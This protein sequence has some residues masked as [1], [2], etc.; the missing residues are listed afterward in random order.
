MSTRSRDL[1]KLCCM[2]ALLALAA[3]FQPT[4]AQAQCTSSTGVAG[5]EGE[6][7]DPESASN[8]IGST[9]CIDEF[10]EERVFQ[11]ADLLS[12]MV[13][14]GIDDALDT[15]SARAL[16]HVQ[17]DGSVLATSGEF[18]HPIALYYNEGYFAGTGVLIGME[19]R[20]WFVDQWRSQGDAV[21]TEHDAFGPGFRVEWGDRL[22]DPVPGAEVVSRVDSTGVTW[23]HALVGEIPL[24]PGPGCT[25]FTYEGMAGSRLVYECHDIGGVPTGIWFRE[26]PDRRRVQYDA[27]PNSNDYRIV[28]EYR[29]DFQTPDWEVTY[30]Y[31][32][33]GTLELIT[34]ARGVEYHFAWTLIGGVPRVTSI[35]LTGPW[36]YG[37]TNLT[38]HFEYESVWP[39]RLERI[40]KPSRAF[41]EDWNRD[42]E[43]QTSEFLVGEIITRFT[44]VGNTYRISKIYDESSGSARLETEIAYE[45][46]NDGRVDWI[47]HGEPGSWPAGQGQ[48]VHDLSYAVDETHWT[49]PRGVE[50]RYYY[51]TSYGSSPLQWRIVRVEEIPGPNDAR[52]TTNPD[53]HG[54]LAWDFTWN[55][56]CG[57]LTSITTPSGLVY[58]FEYDAEG[59][60]LVTEFRIE[61][62]GGV[63][64]QHFRTWSY[65]SWDHP[66]YRIA[67][68]LLQFIDAEG[69][70]G[71]VDYTYQVATQEIRARLS[72][73]GEHLVDI[74]SDATDRP[75]RVE[76]AAFSIKGGGTSKNTLVYEHGTNPTDASYGL[77]VGIHQLDAGGN[78]AWSKTFDYDGLA[79]RTQMTDEKGR[80]TNYTVNYVGWIERIDLP[81]TPSGL[82][83]ATYGAYDEYERTR[84]GKVAVIRSSADRADGTPYPKGIVETERVFDYHGRLWKRYREN[85]MLDNATASSFV[86]EYEYDDSS[87]LRVVRGPGAFETTFVPDDHNA[88]YEYRQKIDGTT[89]SVRS[90]G[91]HEDGQPTRFVDAT[92]IESTVD[93]FDSFGR[94]EWLTLPAGQRVQFVFDKENR[95]LEE[96][97]YTGPNP[98]AL[99]RSM[100][101]DRDALGRVIAKSMESPSVTTSWTVTYTRNGPFRM[102]TLRDGNGRQLTF[103]YDQYG[104]LAS[105]SDNLTG[106]AANVLRYSRDALG[107]VHTLEQDLA[108]QTGSRSFATHTYMSTMQYDNWDRLVRIDRY[109]EGASILWTRELAYDSLDNLVRFEDATGAVTE[110]DFDVLGRERRERRF[111]KGGTNFIE[112]LTDYDDTPTDPGISSIM[113]RTDDRGNPSVYRFD[114]AG[115]LIE[116]RLPGY[117]AGT[118]THRQLLDYDLE[119]R[120]VGWTD[121]NGTQVALHYDA[122]GRR[123][124]REVLG[125]PSNAVELSRMATE[126]TWS[127][128]N[129][130]RTT[131]KMTWRGN[132]ATLEGSAAFGLVDSGASFDDI[133][134]MLTTSF[135]FGDDAAAG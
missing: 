87:R 106:G 77:L 109:G 108:R 14:V 26:Y 44:Y 1:F 71:T 104:R 83:S 101:W 128:D 93:S 43:Y 99:A 52:P 85:G 20:S 115:R 121:G 133:D 36:T 111:E 69:N 40:R 88:L 132:Y 86:V 105:R 122:A 25:P 9:T 35:S 11:T 31:A 80:T 51:D 27:N 41:V 13:P 24:N 98:Q 59:R 62:V 39:H 65:H 116:R 120:P 12:S 47:A 89:E 2:L 100:V 55:C 129:L 46:G 4:T 135:A 22:I 42:G 125:L 54:M 97:L 50:F 96:R 70:S 95:K 131:G 17:R 107:F 118:G 56:S 103:E 81:A 19:Y 114:L 7:C 127:Y 123:E 130:D 82:G 38:T 23:D 76:E 48:L 94:V 113:T 78:V 91:Y 74:W 79:Y 33:D 110:H 119:G 61:P 3:R 75:V 58:R 21:A 124:R 37:W 68:K 16:S 6:L 112:T 67:S 66:N 45:A 57:E 60:S 49:D 10:P 72:Y 32:I 5:G 84:D 18:R 30:E 102:A 34:D 126:E 53:Y 90:F 73:A 134:R 64:V 8:T 29:G 63:G 15:V 28:R 92:G 117:N